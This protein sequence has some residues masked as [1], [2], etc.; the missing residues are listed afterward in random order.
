[1]RAPGNWFCSTF[2]ELDLNGNLVAIDENIRKYFL[3]ALPKPT[4]HA[5]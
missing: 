3:P 2:F 5:A 4:G 1:M